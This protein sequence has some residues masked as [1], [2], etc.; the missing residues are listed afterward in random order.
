[1]NF[2]CMFFSQCEAT[3]T[4]VERVATCHLPL[5]GSHSI[6]DAGKGLVDARNWSGVSHGGVYTKLGRQ[7][8]PASLSSSF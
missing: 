8:A 1:M 3:F 5:D 2:T 6:L 4:S 7:E